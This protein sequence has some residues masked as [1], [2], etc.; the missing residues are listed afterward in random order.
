[1]QGAAGEPGERQVAHDR[2]LLRLGRHAGQAEARGP[3]ALVHDAA[4]RERPVL[5]VLADHHAQVGGV[6]QRPAQQ[7]GVAGAVPLVDE[8]AHAQLGQF[9]HRREAALAG[10]PRW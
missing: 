10:R 9:R 1:M 5:G 2:E 6:L 4:G 7:A 8:E 3:L